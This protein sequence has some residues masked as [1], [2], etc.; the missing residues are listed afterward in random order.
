M[1]VLTLGLLLYP[2]VPDQNS[3]TRR[4]GGRQTG[5]K[6]AAQAG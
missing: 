5:G 2:A 3:S 1:Q 4:Q 6:E